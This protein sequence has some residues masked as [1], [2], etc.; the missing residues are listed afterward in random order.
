[1]ADYPGTD[2]AAYAARRPKFVRRVLMALGAA[3]V[4]LMALSVW[5]GVSSVRFRK[6]ERPF[7]IAFAQDLSRRWQFDDV[8]ARLDRQFVRQSD[9]D[10]GRRS[11][12]RFS[13]LG[14]LRS[15]DDFQMNNF[16]FDPNG[17]VGVFSFKG[18]FDHG[19]ALM[20][21]TLSDRRG[22]VR[23][24]GLDISR[25]SLFHGSGRLQT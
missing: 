7:V 17:S 24:L 5:V 23:V 4:V 12:A 21:V 6:R 8:Y 10:A 22:T 19:A 2:G 13:R 25:V 1:M 9:T 3:A 11:L 16:L 14:A 18:T 20:R 15:V